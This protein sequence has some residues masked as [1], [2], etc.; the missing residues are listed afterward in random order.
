MLFR[1]G[2]IKQGSAEVLYFEQPDVHL[3]TVLQREADL[4]FSVSQCLI[5]AGKCKDVLGKRVHVLLRRVVIRKGN[6]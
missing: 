4:V 5:D 1:A 2:K 3:Q 6:K